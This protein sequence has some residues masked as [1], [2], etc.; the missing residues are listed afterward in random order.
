MK[1]S[2]RILPVV[3][4]AALLACGTQAKADTVA[5]TTVPTTE[6]DEAGYGITG[7][8][9]TP[10]ENL[11]LTQLGFTAID[12]GGGDAPHVTLSSVDPIT[13]APTQMYDTG[14]ILGSVTSTTDYHPPTQSVPTSTSYVSVGTPIEL[15]AG[16]TYLISAPA[17]WV[18]TYDSSTVVT[19]PALGTVTFAHGQSYNSGTSTDTGF[20]W[21]GW[22]NSGYD[23]N[24]FVPNDSG[25]LSAE[26]NFQFNVD[27]DQSGPTVPEP[28][29]YALLGA[30]LA[31]LALKFRR[32]STNFTV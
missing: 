11:D 27:P 19:D 31:V 23:L 26:V 3:A 8:Y 22:A 24:S 2:L 12:L 1:S 5:Y 7:M 15:V 14:D 21:N 10:T 20:N 16:T 9:F 30:G 25:S 29:T 13:G 18:A 28:S 32:R 4:C 17:Y 6:S